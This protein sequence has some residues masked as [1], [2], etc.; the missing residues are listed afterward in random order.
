[1]AKAGSALASLAI[2]KKK[3]ADEDKSAVS[4]KSAIKIKMVP[5]NMSIEPKSQSAIYIANVFLGGSINCENFHC[6]IPPTAI[7]K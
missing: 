6:Q 7:F 1:M 3:K 2:G 5:I 4:I